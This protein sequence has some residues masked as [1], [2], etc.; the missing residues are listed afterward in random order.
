MRETNYL[1]AAPPHSHS[2]FSDTA[3]DADGGDASSA[4][5]LVILHPVVPT[6]PSPPLRLDLGGE[7]RAVCGVV[8]RLVCVS[9]SV[10][11]RV[12][13]PRLLWMDGRRRDRWW[14]GKGG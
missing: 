3:G 12:D 1:P 4:S 13:R 2:S 6:P 7:V 5:P 8:I 11:V 9:V 10:Q 14:R